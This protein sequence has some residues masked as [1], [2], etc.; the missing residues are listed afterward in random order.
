VDVTFSI[1]IGAVIQIK[2]G[3]H[4]RDEKGRQMK[5]EEEE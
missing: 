5:E 4:V 3:E 2:W 1:V